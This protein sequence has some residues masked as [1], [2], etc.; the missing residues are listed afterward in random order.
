MVLTMGAGMDAYILNP[1]DRTMIG[2]LRAAQ[3]LMGQDKFCMN[4]LAAH[5]AG[6]YQQAKRMGRRERKDAKVVARKEHPGGR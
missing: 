2:L 4:Y 6:L 1:L 5:R 3:A